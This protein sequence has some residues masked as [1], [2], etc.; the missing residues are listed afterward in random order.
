MQNQCAANLRVG[1]KTIGHRG[2]PV[3]LLACSLLC[4]HAVAQS[5]GP[6]PAGTPYDIDWFTID[7]GGDSSSAASRVLEGTAIMVQV[8]KYK[9]PAAGRRRSLPRQ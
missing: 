7:G 8:A 2:V 5:T 6:G 4:S 9:L 1:H 3:A